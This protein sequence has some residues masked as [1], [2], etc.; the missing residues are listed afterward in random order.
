MLCTKEIILED[1]KKK[2][3]KSNRETKMM[4]IWSQGLEV[5]VCVCVGNMNESSSNRQKLKFLLHCYLQAT[6][7]AK[8]DHSLTV[9][10]M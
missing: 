3:E 4:K 10:E 6:T 9:Y 2:K 1:Q 7:Y 8:F 5:W